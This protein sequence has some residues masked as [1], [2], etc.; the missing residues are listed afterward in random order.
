MHAAAR[1]GHAAQGRGVLFITAVSPLDLRACR[2]NTNPASQRWV[3]S[4]P[5]ALP[6]VQDSCRVVAPKSISTPTQQGQTVKLTTVCWPVHAL[7]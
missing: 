7:L 2:S 4:L 5:A 3:I 6:V 1:E